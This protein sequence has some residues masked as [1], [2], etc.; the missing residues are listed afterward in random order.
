MNTINNDPNTSS[1]SQPEVTAISLQHPL[2]IG[3]IFRQ[4]RENKELTIDTVAKRLHLKKTIIIQLENNELPD[5]ASTF[6]RGYIRSYAKLLGLPES[7]LLGLISE[8]KPLEVSSPTPLQ[9]YSIEKK[10]RRRDVW[11]K[12]FSGLIVFTTIG[13]TGAWWLQ[14]YQQDK[15]SQ[16]I[17]PLEQ[18]SNTQP[19]TNE[20]P[21]AVQT[22]NQNPPLGMNDV[23]LPPVVDNNLTQ[24]LG[25][26]G[27]A[28]NQ[29]PIN[30][31]PLAGQNTTL[32]LTTLSLEEAVNDTLAQK[33][34][35]ENN[36]I[37]ENTTTGSAGI[38]IKFTGECWV[39]VANASGIVLFS[40][41]KRN[42]DE[43]TFPEG[44][45]FKIK[46]GV[47]SV[48]SIHFDGKPFDLTDFIK[49]GRV[50]KFTI[51][52]TE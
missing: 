52:V 1:E 46:L 23:A 40:G 32:P 36:E 39:E 45:P 6:V 35:S 28:L 21:L 29:T 44:A 26:E 12:V 15:K 11:F 33:T 24:P 3:E 50:A 48:A 43:L 5:V 49:S 51:P 17:T 20:L 4:E 7:Q 37:A 18:T 41:L 38:S 19:A 22:N 16:T 34:N 30:S 9:S 27:N 10:K 25:I 8:D 47:P 31:D 42:G 2:T 13:V 14:N